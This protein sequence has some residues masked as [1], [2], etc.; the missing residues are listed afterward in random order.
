MNAEYDFSQIRNLKLVARTTFGFNFLIEQKPQ[1]RTIVAGTKGDM[2][3]DTFHRLALPYVYF[4]VD[5]INSRRND[6]QAVWKV[7][8]NNMQ[9]VFFSPVPI[10][11]FDQQLYNTFFP[12]VQYDGYVCLGDQHVSMYFEKLNGEAYRKF[13]DKI[14]S[15]FWQSKFEYHLGQAWHTRDMDAKGYGLDGYIHLKQ[16]ECVSKEELMHTMQFNLAEK[17]ISDFMNFDKI[18]YNTL[19]TIQA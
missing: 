2:F 14:L 15:G 9:Y 19:E 3:A 4:I 10:T 1:T 8:S 5:V 18:V 6:H 7:L 13:V 11:N 12:N 17:S 16:L